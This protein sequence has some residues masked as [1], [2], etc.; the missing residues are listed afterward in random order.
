M[1]GRLHQHGM[2]MR[3]LRKKVDLDIWEVAEL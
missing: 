2:E 1:D 3:R